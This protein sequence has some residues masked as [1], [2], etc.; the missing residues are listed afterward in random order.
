MSCPYTLSGLIVIGY[1]LH[2]SLNLAQATGICR[3][4]VTISSKVK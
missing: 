1:R 4:L 3:R 2:L